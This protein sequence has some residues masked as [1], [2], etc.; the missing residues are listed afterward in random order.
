M[1]RRPV[2]PAASTFRHLPEAVIQNALSES[3]RRD[4]VTARRLTLLG[5]LSREN[6]QTQASLILRTEA[7]LGQG[8]FG[9]AATLAFR[10]DMQAVKM[11]LAVSGLSLRYSRKAES[12]GYHIE[13]RPE[14]APEVTRAIHGAALEIDPHQIAV[15][16][17][18]APPQ[19]LR[20]A[21]RLTEDV[22]AIAVRR[23]QQVRPELTRL[24][25]QREVLHRAYQIPG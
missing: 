2:W 10:R 18:L 16:G 1:V 11:I 14:L 17:R 21:A 22:L 6:H 19:R 12:P 9:K 25:A 24:E 4:P 7:R 5:L 23:L 8:C 13:G 3:V 15:F 20:L